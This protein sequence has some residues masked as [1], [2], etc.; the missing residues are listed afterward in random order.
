M[1]FVCVFT[2]RKSLNY[3]NDENQAEQNFSIA[4]KCSNLILTKLNIFILIN[5]VTPSMYEVL[6]SVLK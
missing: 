4:Y 3:F 1:I 5:K 2:L 6:N